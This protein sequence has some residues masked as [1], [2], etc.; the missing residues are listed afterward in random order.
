MIDKTR[1]KALQIEAERNARREAMA[2]R[3]IERAAEERRNVAAGNPGDIDFISLVRDW[4][5]SGNVV[6]EDH[7]HKGVSKICISVRKRPVSSKERAKKDHDSITCANPHVHVHSAKLKVD[8]ITKYLDNNSFR[9]DH[10]FDETETTQD[11][12][13]YTTMPLVDFVCAG[14]GGRATCFAYGQTGSG[15]TY[16]M[17]GIQV[18][19]A[20]DIYMLLGEGSGCR[21]DDTVVTV[22]MFELY[23]GRCQDLLNDRTR[24]K[25]LE[26]GKGEVVVTGLEEVRLRKLGRE[27]CRAISKHLLISHP[28]S[29]LSLISHRLSTKPPTLVIS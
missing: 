20:E 5:D 27:P 10:S 14:K 12:Y 16:T 19:V 13:K 8:G 24:L 1:Q 17:G 11:V 3:K 18:M 6:R 26:D 2:A 21:D 7:F 23:G 28:P 15:K 22:S 29:S 25:I 4:R 9:F